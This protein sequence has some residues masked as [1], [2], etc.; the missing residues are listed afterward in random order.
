MKETLHIYIR[1]SGKKQIENSVPRQRQKGIEFSE[2]KGMKYRL[3]IDEGKSRFGR[4]DKRE[5]VTELFK[6][7][8]I[9][10]VKHIW[11]EDW[12]RLTGELEETLKIE[13]YVLHG[14][15]KIYEGLSGNRV[16]EPTDK[17]SKM[18]TLMKTMY[19]TMGKEDEIEKS[20]Q[21]KIRMFKEGCYMK[22]DPP[23][24]YKIVD[25][26][27]KIDRSESVWVEKI[28]DWYGNKNMSFSEIRH[29]FKV[30][31][32]RTRRS[33]SNH[34]GDSQLTKLL[35]NQ[36]YIGRD[37]Y[38]DRSKD[39]HFKEPYDF[40]FQ[41]DLLWGF[42][43]NECPRIIKDVKLF[44]KVQKKMNRN[45]LRP[46]KK[47][48]FLHGKLKCKCGNDWVGRWYSKYNIPFYHCLNNERGYYKK[49]PSRSHLHSNK[50]SKPKR[51]NG[52]DLDNYVWNNFLKTVEKSVWIKEQVKSELLGEKYGISSKRKMLN[53]E[54]KNHQK[55]IKRLKDSK[56][57]LIR[58]KYV[59]GSIK[60]IDFI[61][62]T[63][64][65]DLRIKD[66]EDS[67]EQLYEKENLM[68]KRKDW[69]DWLGYHDKNIESYRNITNFKERRRVIDYYIDRII[70]DYNKDTKQHIIDIHYKYPIVKDKLI[71]KGGKLNWDKWG[72]GYKVKDGEEVYSISSTDFF[73]TQKNY[74]TLLHGYRLS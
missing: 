19:T 44:D 25:K 61:D 29:E 45:K 18:W 41:D 69:I 13:T 21:Q 17:M 31:N 57:N 37:F 49:D 35:T 8:E 65:I 73:V 22:G 50:C 7:V 47:E 59:L 2:Q 4:L 32:V 48:Y 58:D 23:F 62:M 16:F 33:K 38:T 64:E 66:S 68:N 55:E 12:S 9:G 24:G 3:W 14:K 36:N 1:C 20:I 26:K 5:S 30:N 40:P 56:S 11:V 46:T 71:R 51:I 54:I 70:V 42:Y 39:P 27:L 43:E 15:V 53:S 74:Q 72:N 67:L 60:E 6:L 34:W 63:K 10:S 52:I 28:Y